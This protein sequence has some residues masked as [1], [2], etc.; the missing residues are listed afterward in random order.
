MCVLVCVLVS[1]HDVAKTLPFAAGLSRNLSSLLAAVPPRL[2]LQKF[3]TDYS[4]LFEFEGQE[5]A[6]LKSSMVQTLFKNI[7]N[8]GSPPTRR[9][10]CRKWRVASKKKSSVA[11]ETLRMR[12][13]GWQVGS[14]RYME[15]RDRFVKLREK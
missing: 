11:G 1:L 8:L 6:I 13:V 10:F 7:I 14:R 5:F 4:I 2:K 15:V 9:I 3:A 12:N